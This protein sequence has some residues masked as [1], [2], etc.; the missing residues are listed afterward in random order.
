MN[1]FNFNNYML[2]LLMNAHTNQQLK[3]N[4]Q[5]EL[6][7]IFDSFDVNGDGKLDFKELLGQMTQM[8]DGARAKQE[9]KRIFEVCDINNDGEI[10]FEEF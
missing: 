2:N 5:K 10:D 1:Q 6:R 7:G 8:Y 3:A 9:C 4:E